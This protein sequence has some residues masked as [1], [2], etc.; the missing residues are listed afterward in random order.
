MFERIRFLRYAY[1]FERAFKS[2]DWRAVRACFADDAV[3]VMHGIT[4]GEPYPAE[5]RGADAIVAL[6]KRML[7]EVDRRFDRRISRPTS[8]LHVR[9]GELMMRWR[10]L[11]IRGKESVSL[12]G[13]LRCRFAGSLIVHLQDT[14]DSDEAARWYALA[15]QASA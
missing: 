1:R 5:T 4:P 12:E 6:F 13:E 2:D 11:Y 7:D 3:Y 9:D 8:W 14:M 15:R 10:V